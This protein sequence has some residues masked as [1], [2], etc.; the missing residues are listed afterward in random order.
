DFSSHIETDYLHAFATE[1]GL[2]SNDI[3]KSLIEEIKKLSLSPLNVTS[4]QSPLSISDL[5]ASF[6]GEVANTDVI[7][8]SMD[9]DQKS[10]LYDFFRYKE[11]LGQAILYFCRALLKKDKRAQDTFAALQREG[12]W[13]DVRD[14]KI[15]VDTGLQAAQATL[16]ESI[17]FSQRF[18]T[19][20]VLLEIKVDDVLSAMDVLQ[21]TVQKIDHNVETL[22]QEFRQFMHHF[23][24]S[25]Q[26]TAHDEFTY[27]SS[28]SLKLIDTAVTKLKASPFQNPEYHAVL[29]MAGSVLSST[30]DIVEAEKLLLQ[31][32]ET[33]Q[34]PTEKA[35][36]SFN[37]FQAQLRNQDYDKALSNLQ[38]AINIDASH[39]AL[40]D[41]DRYPIIKLLGAGSMGCVFLCHDQWREHKLLVTCFWEGRKGERD[42]VF[43]EALQMRQIVGDCVLKPVDCG[44]TN[45]VKQE[46]PYFVTEYL[47]GAIDGNQWLKQQG[48]FDATTGIKVGLEIA[49]GLQIA[50]KKGIFHLDLKP[51]NLLFKN[52]QDGL[53][54]KIIEFGLSQVAISLQKE[55]VQNSAATQFGQTIVAETRDYSPPEKTD[56]LEARAKKD[57][58]AFGAT[59]Y[60]LMTAK[61]P[62][63]M[64]PRYLE[65]APFTLYQLLCNCQEENPAKRPDIATVVDQLSTLMAKKAGDIIR[66]TL[67]DGTMGAEMIWIPAGTF[68]MG[69]IQGTGND[70]EKPIHDVTLDAFAIGK[71]TV[72]FAEYDKFIEA[73]SGSKPKDQG[74]GRENRPVIN[75]SW[76]DAIAYADWFS[77]QTGHEYRLPTE[78]EWEYAAR[79]GTETDYWWG[80]K[81]GVN[82]CNCSESRS[83][84]SGK[85]TDPVGSFKANPWGLHDTAGN[86]WER[87]QDWYEESYYSSRPPP[88]NNPTGPSGDSYRYRVGRGGSWYLGASYVRSAN[89]YWIRAGLCDSDL[90]FRLVRML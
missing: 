56:V 7:L 37:L 70:T 55:I 16:Q 1:N 73:T 33:A 87:V 26:M 18:D 40:H 69:D 71:Y 88:E 22:L 6:K 36:A 8:G 50:H 38:I 24:L 81:L 47:E 57:L 25:A 76:N 85:Q 30:G 31:A 72:T 86:V 79:A 29:M 65:H 64:N 90:G 17:D 59:L 20:T 61:S 43:G 21:W 62:R 19:W 14:I 13:A 2:D 46:R 39:Y 66:D 9:I 49:K 63:Y 34:S 48:T 23:E 41:I 82:R 51:A 45:L 3:R 83:R 5:S 15:S 68:K 4:D 27:H 10:P 12:L 53:Q 42:E 54:V 11:L 44:Y 35:L 74:W 58:Y 80:N 89:R 78:A 75:I 52:S 60:Y 28:N 67:E 84:W 77:Q 32:Q